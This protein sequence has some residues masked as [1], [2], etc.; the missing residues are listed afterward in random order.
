MPQQFDSQL[1]TFIRSLPKTETHLHIEGALP[2][3]LLQSIDPTKFRDPPLSWNNDF[4][5]ES[6]SEFEESLI[7][8]ALHWFT[9]PERYHKAAKSIFNKHLEQNVKYVEISFHAGIIDYFKIPGPEIINAIRDAIP[10]GLEVRVFMGMLRNQ[11]TPSM[12]PVIDDC[13]NWEKLDGIDLHGTELLPLEEWTKSLWVKAREANKFTKAHAGE[14]GGPSNVKK[15]IEILGVNR[16]EHGIRA[17]ENNDVISMVIDKDITFDVCPISN[18]KLNVIESMN[19]HPIRLLFDKGV[20]CTL[21]TD[22]PLSFGNQLEEEY[23]ALAMELEFSK[24]E[25]AILARNGF[26]I[27]LMPDSKKTVFIKQINDIIGSC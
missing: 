1:G 24:K 5:F 25:L 16:V 3:K 7:T 12:A 18:L 27:A 14:F 26:E 4:K 2:F 10:D 22:D 9:S 6:F 23:V 21:N 13:L 20:R 11:Y 19:N 17:I 8:M 15:A